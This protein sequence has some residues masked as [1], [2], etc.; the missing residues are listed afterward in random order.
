VPDK[1]PLRYAQSL[2]RL[3]PVPREELRAELQAMELPLVLLQSKAAPDLEIAVE[4]YGRLFI[5]LVR[6]LQPE[7]GAD[8]EELAGIVEFSTYH[9]LFVA[10]T[11]SRNLEQAMQRAAM[12]FRRFESHGDTFVL[13]PQG[14]S[15]Q[16]RFN[17][18][19]RGSQRDLVAAENFDMSSLNWLQGDTGRILSIALWHRV[20]SWF[21]GAPI[22]LESVNLAQ[23]A[24]NSSEQLTE[25]FGI[26][27]QFDAANFSFVFHRRYLEFPIV[28]GETAVKAMLQNFPADIL[29]LDPRANSLS[30][31]VL[32][33]IGSDFSDEVPTLQQIAD[34][35]HMT[36]PTLHRR[37]RDEGGAFQQLKDQARREAA[38]QLI[39]DGSYSGQQLAELTGFSD[40]STFHRA[41]KKWT[42]LTPQAFRE[43]DSP[44]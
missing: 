31:R 37:L 24:T 15:I 20:C 25:I 44:S 23:A 35:L 7:L 30:E 11:H 19:D 2:L 29:K 3:S 33:L 8:I 16:C 36:T 27:A 34:R 9:M 42:G 12:Y 1:I 43:Q 17:F 10:M 28:Q 40:A 4:D 18:S 39:R 38:V 32:G 5:H 6:K 13:E 14:D 26:A 41:F 22:E 21:I